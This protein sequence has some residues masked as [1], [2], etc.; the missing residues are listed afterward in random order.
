MSNEMF[1]FNKFLNTVNQMAVTAQ[2]TSEQMG[3]VT[4]MVKD[5]EIRIRNN[6]NDYSGLRNDF[7]TYKTQQ[8]E[9]EFISPDKVQN[10][11]Q[12]MTNRVADLLKSH[13]ISHD[14]WQPFMR[15]AWTD[16]KSKAN[17]V[18]KAGVYT[19]EMHYEDAINYIGRWIPEGYGVEGY[20]EHLN[21]VR[22]QPSAK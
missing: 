14:Y 8:S 19:K 2:T 16:A 22:K 13:N 4:T 12:V 11:R 10:I 5:H 18:G 17:V 3:I 6:E 15:K 7:E 21:I 9:K 20:V 1:D